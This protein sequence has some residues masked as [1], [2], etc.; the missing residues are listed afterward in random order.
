MRRM[1]RAISL[2]LEAPESSVCKKV[3]N[4]GSE[5]EE[6]QMLPLASLIANLVR[7][8]DVEVVPDDPDKRSYHVSFERI[9]KRTWVQKA[10]PF[11][12]CSFGDSECPKDKR[13]N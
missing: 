7:N 10:T 2:V 11:G 5:E 6:F 4:C 1:Q 12:R 13:H 3:F 9:K 8:T